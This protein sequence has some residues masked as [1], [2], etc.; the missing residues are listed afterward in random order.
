[1]IPLIYASSENDDDERWMESDDG[2]KDNDNVNEL[3]KEKT[4]KETLI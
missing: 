3:E 2:G 4:Q 1:M